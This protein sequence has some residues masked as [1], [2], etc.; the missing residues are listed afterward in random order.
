MA[1]IMYEVGVAT[2]LRCMKC[3]NAALTAYQLVHDNG[4]VVSR[5]DGLPRT[6]CQT[7]GLWQHER[8]LCPYS[9]TAWKII[10]PSFLTRRMVG[11]GDPFY[12]K[13]WIKLTLLE[14]KRRY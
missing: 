6:F 3:E 1:M 13:F 8:N 10:N 7:R 4:D 5:S 14:R 12:L 2:P 11:G 9:Y